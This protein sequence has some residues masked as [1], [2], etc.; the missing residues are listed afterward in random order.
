MFK[1]KN[2]DTRMMSMVTL[3]LTVNI[4]HTF[5]YLLTLNRQTFEVTFE[6]KVGYIMRSVVVF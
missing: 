5:L 4:F 6:D 2:E 3:L 1:I